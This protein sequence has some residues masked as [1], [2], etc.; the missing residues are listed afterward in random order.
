MIKFL[1]EDNF[2]TPSSILLRSSYNG[3]NCILERGSVKAPSF[4]SFNGGIHL[5]K[6]Q[7]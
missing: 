5:V 7:I 2:N 4:I 1:F 3:S 6:N